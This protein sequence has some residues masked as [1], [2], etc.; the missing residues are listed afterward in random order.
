MTSPLHTFNLADNKSL[1]VKDSI[2]NYFKVISDLSEDDNVSYVHNF[3]SVGLDDFTH[4]VKFYKLFMSNK[5]DSS[6]SA[7]IWSI[8][9]VG[10][11]KE[12]EL[13]TPLDGRTMKYFFPEWVNTF[14]ERFRFVNDNTDSHIYI[15]AVARSKTDRQMY[16][17]VDVRKWSPELCG[18][19]D[20]KIFRKQW[21]TKFEENLIIAKREYNK[22]KH[23]YPIKRVNQIVIAC[24]FLNA[25]EMLKALV[26]WVTINYVAMKTPWEIRAAGCLADDVPDEEKCRI[27]QLD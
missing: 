19:D 14:M 23:Y 8:P 20:V 15:H 16:K 24:A 21:N 1:Q 5:E 12:S 6:S 9:E 4:I 2:V 7:K 18:C 27:Y 10:S 25:N 3:P 26:Y 11:I 17:G 22:N 13:I